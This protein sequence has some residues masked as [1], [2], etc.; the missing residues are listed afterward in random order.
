MPRFEGIV[1]KITYRNEENGFTV[2]QVKLEGGERLAAVGAMPLL[3][4]GERAAFE[5]E[6]VEH[7]EYGRQIRVTWV[8]SIRPESLDGIEKYLA[9]G[10]I[11]GVGE[12]TARLIVET[13]GARTLDVLEAEPHRLTEVP[14]I[15]EKR[16]AM[17]ALS[18]K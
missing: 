7:R 17:I 6:M 12:A 2:A 10:L 16:A 4:A 5:G 14:G 15:G 1:E 9:S 13:F 18:F 8:E 3:L 11:R